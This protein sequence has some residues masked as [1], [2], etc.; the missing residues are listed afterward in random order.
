MSPRNVLDERLEQLGSA[1]RERPS[2]TDR[3]M[4][5]LHQSLADGS[6]CVAVG[7]S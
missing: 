6:K 3:V 2:V 7:H 1:L 5:Q 4:H